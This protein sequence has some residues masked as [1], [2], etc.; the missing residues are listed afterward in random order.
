MSRYT[1]KP[2]AWY[3]VIKDG[4]FFDPKPSLRLINHSPD[5]FAWG[6]G[7]SGPAQ[8]ALG[9]LLDVT[10][11]PKFAMQHYQ[12]FKFDVIAHLPQEGGWTL[13][14]E[15]IE[16]WIENWVLNPKLNIEEGSI[17]R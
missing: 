6:Y 16:A 13:T 10:G 15:D 4:R 2:N 3:T 14:T 11:N 12:K 5:G 17:T 1:P 7:G 9:L 8:F